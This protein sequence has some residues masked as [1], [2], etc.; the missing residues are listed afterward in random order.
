MTAASTGWSNQPMNRPGYWRGALRASRQAIAA[1]CWPPISRSAAS[2]S[3]RPGVRSARGRADHRAARPRDW[4]LPEVR[5]PRRPAHRLRPR[6]GHAGALFYLR[7]IR[8]GQDIRRSAANFPSASPIAWRRRPEMRR[9]AEQPG[10]PMPLQASARPAPIAASAAAFSQRRMGAAV[11]RSR[12]I[13]P[14]RLISAGSAPREPR[15]AKRSA[16]A[17]ACCIRCA[18]LHPAATSVSA[19]RRRWMRS[20]TGSKASSPRMGRTPSPLFIRAAPHR[21]LLPRQQADE[22]LH[23]LTPCRH[24]FAALHGLDRRRPAPRLRLRHGAGQL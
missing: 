9:D 23:R 16:S 4:P 21:G 7:L 5:H 12:A 15:S 20:P 6:R 24:Q 2:A 1:R 19:G 3:S 14:I 17:R 22:G 8:S 18:A 11:R 10:P 13:R